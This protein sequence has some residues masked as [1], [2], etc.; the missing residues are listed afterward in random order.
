VTKLV[1]FSTLEEE[2]LN[3]KNAIEHTQALSIEKILKIMHGKG[4]ALIMMI[5]ALPFCQPLQIPGLSTPFGLIIAFL[6]LRTLFG[7]GILLPKFLIEKKLKRKTVEKI[8]KSGL[9]LVRK[10]KKVLH[11]RLIFLCQSKSMRVFNEICIVFLGLFLALPLPIPL[12][13]LIAAWAILWLNLGILEDDGLI[14]LFGYFFFFVSLVLFGVIVYQL[15][16]LRV[17]F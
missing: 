8:I 10:L 4:R 1:K 17:F 13:N 5:L 9:A 11:P 15:A 16:Y 14:V 7:N 2:F 12:S 3:L 6:G